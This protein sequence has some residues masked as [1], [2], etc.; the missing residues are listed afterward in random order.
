MKFRG[1]KEAEELDR[2]RR[3][4][5]PFEAGSLPESEKERLCRSLL[6]EFGIDRVNPSRD[7]E[8]VHACLLPFKAHRNQ[9]HDPTAS[10]NFKK[11]TY[12][13][14]GCQSGGGLLWFIGTVRGT[15]A[16]EARKWLDNQVGIGGEMQDLPALLKF[17]DEVYDKK[18][19]VYPPLPKID[20]S[21]INPWLAIHPYLTEI[22][23]VPE[24]NVKRFRVGYGKL[25]V[26]DQRGEWA[27]SERI[28][29]PHF[30]KG[31]LV[32]WQS[33]RLYKDGTAKY[34]NTADF[35]KDQTIYNFDPKQVAVVVEGPL[36]VIRHAHHVP[37]MESTFSA[38]VTD[39]Q[40]SLLA[41]HKRVILWFDNDEAGWN[42]TER[43]G[44]ALESYGDVWVVDSP[45]AE[46]PGGM[47]DGTVDALLGDLVPFSVWRRPRELREWGGDDDDVEEVRRQ[48][49][50]TSAA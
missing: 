11:L 48:R 50:G 42:A 37:H 9:D 27:L 15:S 33:R 41:Q 5:Q 23:G 1:I 47:D 26:R 14:F 34:L 17:F 35:P 32:G 49:A 20:A 7:G 39:R 25:K 19:A 2:E 29:I 21:V 22:R 36:S 40:I 28:V 24:D 4:H 45:W 38:S 12:H 13:C 3:Q 43:V 44:T 10:L 18:R 8:L 46:D 16:T 30:W 6:S 31:T